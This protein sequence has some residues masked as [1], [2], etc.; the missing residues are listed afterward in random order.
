MLWLELPGD[1]CDIGDDSIARLHDEADEI[2]AIFVTDRQSDS[3][4]RQINRKRFQLFES[5]GCRRS[6]CPFLSLTGE[7]Y[8]SLQA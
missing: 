1:G 8:F 6:P 7:S 3:K 4:K 2:I 5:S